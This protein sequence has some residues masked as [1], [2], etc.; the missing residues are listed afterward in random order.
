MASI[1]RVKLSDR[2]TLST[3]RLLSTIET[4]EDAPL[5]ASP[6]ASLGP[7]SAL[8]ERDRWVILR[9]VLSLEAL[10]ALRQEAGLLIAQE[11][12]RDCDLADNG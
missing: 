7:V 4:T 2:P 3:P 5:P 8:Y 1:K 9:Q 6:P 10:A 12:K 11:S